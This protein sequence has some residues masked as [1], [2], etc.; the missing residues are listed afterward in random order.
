MRL[1][2]VEH[3]KDLGPQ[4]VSEVIPFFSLPNTSRTDLDTEN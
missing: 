1:L 2:G 4:H 3:V